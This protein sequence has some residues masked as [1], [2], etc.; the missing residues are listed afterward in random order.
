MI[1]GLAYDSFTTSG[2]H[3]VQS[4]LAGVLDRLNTK[5]GG[6]P[7]YLGAMAYHYYPIDTVRWPTI[8]DKTAEIRSVLSA[9]GAGGLPL[10]VPEMGYWSEAVAGHPEFNS[11]E[12]QQATGLVEMFV[13]GLSVG[14]Q[15][16][17]WFAV[18]DSGPG[19]EAHGLFRGI[20]LNSAKPSYSAYAT[21]TAELH[22][23]HYA[24]QLGAAGIE[25]YVFSVGSSQKTVAWATGS[26][27][28][29]TF[30][31]SCLRRVD[32]VGNAANVSDGNPTWDKDTTPG[33]IT[34]KLFKDTPVYVSG[35]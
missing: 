20:D 23:Y 18:F 29:I 10:I 14:I 28:N 5:T 22:G 24:S 35:C 13:R 17:S 21:L 19:T 16:M 3:Y 25:G 26:S 34:L 8:K 15:Q 11:T 6:A 9:H 33:Q 2:G 12:T 1:G 4:F 32:Y 31:Q 27:A 30:H 7:A